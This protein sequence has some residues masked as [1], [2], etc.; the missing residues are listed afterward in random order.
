M[1][2]HIAFDVGD[3]LINT[4]DYQDKYALAARKFTLSPAELIK[5]YTPLLPEME[6]D[7]AKITELVPDQSEAYLAK[8]YQEICS[9]YFK[10]NQEV[11]DMAINLKKDYQVG[12]FS[13]VDRYLAQI[14]VNQLIYSE[15]SPVVL[16]YLEKTRKPDPKI[17]QIY[18]KRANCQPENLLFIDNNPENLPPA[19]QLGI[20]TIHFEN[21]NQLKRDLKKLEIKFLNQ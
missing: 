15:F 13:N 9:E 14:K 6:A 7:R 2:T 11:F 16:S 8:I 3:V 21:Y 5:R 1:I 10:L 12:I 4:G 17:Y 20:Q 19:Q 18:L